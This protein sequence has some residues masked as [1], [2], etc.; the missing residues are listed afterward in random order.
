LRRTRKIRIGGVTIGGGGP[1]A[2]QSM[3][4]ARHDDIA[5][6]VSQA[7][8][9]ELAGCEILRVAIPDKNSVR[10]IPAIKERTSIP[11]VA[12]IHFDHKLAIESAAAG[13]DKIRLNPG[14]IGGEANVRAVAKVCRERGVPIRIG[15]NGG[16]LERE[17]L[18]EYGGPTAEALA[19]SAVRH[20]EMLEAADFEDIVVA[21]KSSDVKTMVQAC[22][23]MAGRRDYPLHL[24]V[25]EAGGRRMGLLRSA[26]GLGALLVDGI[27]DTIRVS[28][29]AP[30]VE[31][32]LAAKDI[33]K[34]LNLHKSGITVVS[35]PTCG[36]TE[37]DV[38]SLAEEI[39]EKLK[40]RKERLTVAVM[41]CVVNG[42]GEAR[43]ADIG[44]CG[45]KDCAALFVK[46]EVIGKF[47]Q[48]EII[49]ALLREIEKKEAGHA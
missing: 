46:G 12:D 17:L 18:A 39:E 25:T 31:E 40:D 15:V 36:R 5:G 11:L 43:E 48:D 8:E 19:E 44:I 32:I 47:A 7:V 35:C 9:L 23:V 37:I 21:I 33:L 26:A 13:A 14:N 6:N 22:R 4:N 2:V 45:G 38:I 24:G 3:L 34:A 49:P 20:A 27:G 41:G 42:P 29:T 28:L 16:S 10:L 30:P 1:I